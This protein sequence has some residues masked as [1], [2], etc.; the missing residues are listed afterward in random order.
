M[1][2][3]EEMKTGRREWLA[4]PKVALKTGQ[5]HFS[6][7]D[8]ASTPVLRPHTKDKEQEGKKKKRRKTQISKWLFKKKRAVYCSELMFWTQHCNFI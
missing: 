6:Q 8:Q 3:A 1:A 4:E 7:S 5:R 2:E